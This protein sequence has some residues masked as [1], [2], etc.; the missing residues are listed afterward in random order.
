MHIN[1]GLEEYLQI[2]EHRLQ[3]VNL[4]LPVGEEGV[5]TAKL[6]FTLAEGHTQAV[7]YKRQL[8]RLLGAP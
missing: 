2:V 5:E 6:L 7:R 4:A 1:V 8:K 3:M